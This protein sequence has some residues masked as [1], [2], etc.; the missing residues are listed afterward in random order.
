PGQRA[1]KAVLG[2]DLL[3]RVDRLLRVPVRHA[4]P[5]FGFMRAH[6]GAVGRVPASGKVGWAEKASDGGEIVDRGGDLAADD[7]I[8]GRAGQRLVRK[9]G[10]PAGAEAGGDALEARGGDVPVRVAAGAIHQIELARRAFDERAAQLGDEIGIVAD[11][12]GQRSREGARIICH[13]P[14]MGRTVLTPGFISAPKWYKRRM[15]MGAERAEAQ[16]QG[17]T[18]WGRTEETAP[19]ATESFD[20]PEYAEAEAPPGSAG[21]R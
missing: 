20:Y 19:A 12:G 1:L 5:S 10:E 15:S 9:H 6:F 11:G 2:R 13:A 21:I 14:N 3:R 4:R 16:P 8:A 17:E 7:R 18:V